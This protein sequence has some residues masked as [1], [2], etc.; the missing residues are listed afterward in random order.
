MVLPEKTMN[1]YLDNSNMID[2]VKFNTPSWFYLSP[3]NYSDTLY[4]KKGESEISVKSVVTEK[5]SAK[6]YIDN[7]GGYHSIVTIGGLTFY[8]KYMWRASISDISNF[9]LT[10]I[11]ENRTE[12]SEYF[13]DFEGKIF[14]ISI[15]D[16]I[17]NHETLLKEILRI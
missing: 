15:D 5:S 8:K 13:F 2:G 7:D 3:N 16:D 11:P 9:D 17:F 4:F 1:T 12:Y 14:S 10:R 6:E